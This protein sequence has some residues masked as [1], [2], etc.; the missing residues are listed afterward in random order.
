MGASPSADGVSAIHSHMTNTL[1]TPIEALE[2]AYPLQVVRYCI[3][4][5]SGGKGAYNGG[6]GIIREIKLLTNAQV[7]L[8]TERRSTQPY[9]LSG[10]APGQRGENKLIHASDVTTLPGKGSFLCSQGDILSIN[11]P[12]G[13]GFGR[14]N[15]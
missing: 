5:N 12:G 13:G 11:T 15:D 6:D 9:S 10:G 14:K 2:Y 8:L 3:R 1:N 7:T 4:E